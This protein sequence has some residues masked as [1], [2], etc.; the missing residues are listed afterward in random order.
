MLLDFQTGFSGAKC[1]NFNLPDFKED[2]LLPLG[3]FWRQR[4][5][6]QKPKLPGKI[7]DSSNIL[8]IIGNLLIYFFHPRISLALR[9]GFF[10]K[11]NSIFY[12]LS[13]LYLF[14]ELT[15]NNQK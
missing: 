7:S 13:T 2:E 3:M 14:I 6:K 12:P 9:Q 5:K 10:L 1:K 15:C 8:N 11:A 4:G